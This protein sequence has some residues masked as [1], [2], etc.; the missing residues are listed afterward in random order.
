[1]FRIFLKI[2]ICFFLFKIFC[3]EI[4]NTLTERINNIPI[5]FTKFIFDYNVSV[6]LGIILM[7]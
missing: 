1:M 6:E 5:H 7:K 2:G 4:N 3:R